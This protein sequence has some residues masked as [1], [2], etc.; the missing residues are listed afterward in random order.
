MS[1]YGKTVFVPAAVLILLSTFN[2]PAH[3]E[4]IPSSQDSASVTV[5]S[6]P[7]DDRAN[8]WWPM[9]LGMQY[10]LIGQSMAPFKSPYS[11][12]NSLKSTGDSA[13]TQTIGI[14]L[15]SR[16]TDRLQA[17]LD[18]EMEKGLG[19]SNVTGL[20]GL[21][22]GDAIRGGSLDLGS[23]PYVARAFLRYFIPLT[24]ETDQ[25]TR[26]MDHLPALEPVSRVDINLGRM[27]VVDDFDI[28][29]YANS[30]RTQFMNWSLINNTA[31][32]FAADTRGFSN[33]LMVAW[34][35]PTW[36][37][38]YGLYQMPTTANG[39][40]FDD[41]SVSRGEN[42]ELT[43][44]ANKNG[45]AIRFLGYQN[46]ARMGNYA[47]ALAAGVP[48]NI[49]AN[50]A[51][52]RTKYGYGINIEQPIANDGETGAFLRYGWNDGKNE[53][54]TFTEVDRLFSIGV[55]ISGANWRREKDIFAIALAQDGLSPD[56]AAYLAA[57]GNGFVLGDGR[58]TYG[59]ETIL[60]SYYR[61]QLGDL[62][63]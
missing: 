29:R 44:Q 40:L 42:V 19:L 53:S 22:N 28:N 17:Y 51:P 5:Q 52:G 38:R 1:R 35:N 55:Q 26:A 41:L 62:Q 54:F 45:A 33:G 39:N 43:L 21:T 57:G 25:V 7:G 50:G 20:G 24:T 30:T 58:L 56:H 60:E 12:I 61:V 27:A 63:Q 6:S 2:L 8:S 31:W 9:V 46:I 3:A 49:A 4:S 16:L 59:P 48:P 18:F 10:T 32:D 34:V 47:A 11:G 13:A 14:Y 15:G 36:S 23:D 37:L